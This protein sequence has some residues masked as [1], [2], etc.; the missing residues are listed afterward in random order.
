MGIV[1]DMPPRGRPKGEI[2]AVLQ[3]AIEQTDNGELHG[4][5]LIRDTDEGTRFNALGACRDRL[6]IGILTTIRGLFHMAE[7]VAA[8]GTA[9]ST[10][11][12]GPIE[13]KYPRRALPKRLRETSVF[14]GLE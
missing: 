13:L 11:A 4:A 6:Q 2:R 10:P 8:S 14:G 1:I 5:I 9:G 3:E 12:T 7:Q